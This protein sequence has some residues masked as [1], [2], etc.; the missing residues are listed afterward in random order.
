MPY[1]TTFLYESCYSL[2]TAV[3]NAIYV[4]LGYCEVAVKY[5]YLLLLNSGSLKHFNWFAQMQCLLTLIF[6]FKTLNEKS[7]SQFFSHIGKHQFC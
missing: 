5:A 4:V 2:V 1:D 3:E 7:L 6:L